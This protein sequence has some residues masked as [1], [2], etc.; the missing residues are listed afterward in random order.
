M[1]LPADFIGRAGTSLPSAIGSNQRHCK[2]FPAMSGSGGGVGV[3]CSPTELKVPGS[4]PGVDRIF[5]EK[6]KIWSSH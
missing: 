1:T 5:S 6:E 4:I 3:A 2:Y